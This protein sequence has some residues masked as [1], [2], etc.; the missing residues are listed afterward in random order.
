MEMK[1]ITLTK[2]L[3]ILKNKIM[4]NII[5]KIILIANIVMGINMMK[6]QNII[7]LGGNNG[8][9]PK[10]FQSTGQ[11]YYKDVYNYL[12][13]F[14]GTWEYVNGN[15]KF[16]IILTKI[17]KYHEVSSSPP[18]MNFNYYTDGI[19][20]RYK[21]FMNGNLIFESP[22]TNIPTFENSNGVK[23][24]GYIIDY[25]RVTKTVNYPQFMGRSC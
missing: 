17:I 8:T 22:I 14:A 12:D 9:L 25:G 18:Y 2:Y 15:E 21:K 11:Y 4:K 7:A 1:P 6:S 24:D 3:A 23:L 19:S 5:I 20:L 10:D 13:G 16:Q